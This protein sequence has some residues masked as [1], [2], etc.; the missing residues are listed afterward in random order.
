MK[1]KSLLFCAL[2]FAVFA[3][4][5]FS[6][7]EEKFDFYTRGAYRTEVPRPQSILRFD[8]GDFHTT[9]AQMEKVI[10]AIA[11]SAPDRVRV[12]DIGETNE[13]R[14]QHIIAIS[15]PENISR[16]DEIKANNAKLTDS[17]K[18]SPVEANQIAQ[19]NPAISWMA[20]T[21]HGNESAS[22]E[23]MMQVA[24]QLAA[25]NEP[26][27]LDILKNNVT[28][29]ITGENPDGHERFVTWYNSVATGNAD[30]N[31]LEHREPWSINGR[32]N[33]F[34]FDLNRDNIAATQ[35]ETHNLQKAFFEWNPQVVVDHHGQPSQY[36]F[37][38]AALPINPNLPQPQTNK[39]L[40]M[41]GR[42]NA[43]AFDHNKW[44]YYVRDI[45]DLFYP[46]YWDSFPAL[47][48]AIGM[49]YETDG[50]GF[51]GLRWTRDDG[52]I[53]TLRSAIAKHYVASLTTLETIAKNR[54][55]R[56]ADYYDFRRTAIEET[57]REK[58]KRIVIDGS[59]DPVKT[60]EM[61]EI[62]LRAKV[63]VKVANASFSSANAH[64]Y[65]QNNAPKVSQ[66]FAAGA[67]VIDLNQPQKRIIKALLE[68]DTPQDA[69][70]VK[71]NMTR[72]RRNERRGS[73][74]QKEEYGFYDITAWNLSLAFGVD[75]F[76]TEDAANI[77]AAIV[78]NE[79]L[80]AAKRGNVS[81]RAQIAYIIPYQTDGAGV[82]ALRLLKEGFRVAVATKTL[83]AGG[84]NWNR[85]TFVVRVTRN[86]ETV[87]EAV[88]RLAKELGVNVTAVNTGYTD[89]GDTNVGSENVVSLQVPKI[90]MVADETVDQT[91]YGSIWWTLDRYKV[92]FTPLT[93]TNIKSG[94]LK[95]YTVLI[96]PNGSAS[97]YFGA[98]GSSGISSLK[99]WI[100][101][102]G[103]LITVKG[104]SVFAALKDV[105]LTSSKL[106]GSSDDEE[107]GKI[108]DG[109]E[110]DKRK[111]AETRPTP[112]T[113]KSK[114]KSQSTENE[115]N[116]SQELKFD[117]ADGAPP[118]LPPIASP[119]A[120]AGQVPEAI[121]G[122]IMRATVDRTS[123]LT[124]G[125]EDDN[126]PVLLSSGYFFRF[127][128]DGTNAL[129]FEPKP[130]NPLTIS[131]FVWEGNTEKL[132]QGTAYLIDEPTG[133]G[134][135]ILF[136][137]EPFFRGIFRTATRPFFNSILFNGT[138]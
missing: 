40:D 131:G 58:L 37:P 59:K 124:Y 14:M 30:R 52:T 39:W 16:L 130:K 101:G 67:Y 122:S 137:E 35:V 92:E 75:A 26:A 64:S 62:L 111:E 23:A 83:T 33:H 98:L 7:A 17:R 5:V 13:H 43:N 3:Q 125:I 27:T 38:P 54:A 107:K 29:I 60:A 90:A 36:F 109:D 96:M 100:S 80:N 97:R 74:A 49:T 129:L 44:D 9:Y 8:V 88:N 117:K 89:E 31:A 69:A 50:G 47:N 77:N 112:T 57:A 11:K 72:F 70:F 51:K 46:G 118:V 76:W 95:N 6:Q 4:N 104:A 42:A 99:E 19:T 22:F 1:L 81:G 41:F 68:Q 93:I 66:T 114:A 21:I 86:A 116:A 126:L 133:A 61:M 120:N 20:Y 2:A 102:G 103:T 138:F 15:A 18:T 53:A 91:S 24:Y 85:G 45:F 28:L 108:A 63:E 34:R 10:D 78:T 82:L 134:H 119:S 48:G 106:V 115:S 32:Y 87:H 113:Q 79:Y 65:S 127:S 12:F 110:N 136:A 135:V 123:Y 71:D 121:P 94:A 84:R 55:S 73:S 25:S 105:G 132:L 56:L 128:K